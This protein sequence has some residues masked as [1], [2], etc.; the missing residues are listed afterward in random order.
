MLRDL[1][2]QAECTVPPWRAL[3]MSADDKAYGLREKAARELVSR[4]EVT[5][6]SEHAAAIPPGD[7]EIAA[8]VDGTLDEVS[9]EIFETRLADDPVLQAEVDGLRELRAT[10]PKAGGRQFARASWKTMGLAATLVAAT[11][12]A[13]WLTVSRSSPVR[14]H[15]SGGMVVMHNDG[16]LDGLEHLPAELDARV[17]EALRT[18]HLPRR[19]G[20]DRL[21]VEDRPLMS[22]ETDRTAFRVM[23]PVGTFVRSDRTVFQWVPDTTASGYQVS[24]YDEHLNPIIESPILDV[25]EWTPPVSLPQDMLLLWQVEATT[26]SGRVLAPT[27]P[28]AQA[29]FQIL[30]DGETWLLQSRLDTVGDSHLARAVILSEAGVIEEARAEIQ[31]L[32]AQ[33]PDA[34]VIDELLASLDA[35]AVTP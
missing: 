26:P 19:P 10:L 29:R 6:A 21:R 8:Y 13:V 15:D 14:L 34:R 16:R 32:K 31:A 30:S 2:E 5:L 22:G 12:A 11:G 20:L 33:N 27:P 24:V 25:P 35:T 3:S 28:D 4:L 9:R 23:R 1:D 17:R 18:G 7:A